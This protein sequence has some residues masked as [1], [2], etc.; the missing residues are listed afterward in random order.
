MLDASAS[1]RRRLRLMTSAMICSCLRKRL[2][3]PAIILTPGAECRL[4][5][6]RASWRSEV[7]SLNADHASNQSACEGTLPFSNAKSLEVIADTARHARGR[8]DAEVPLSIRVLEIGGGRAMPHALRCDTDLAC[9]CIASL[10]RHLDEGRT[11]KRANLEHREPTCAPEAASLAH[12]EH[13]M[14]QTPRW[15]PAVSQLPLSSIAYA[16]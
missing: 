8:D 1:A 11:R 10:A 2:R 16:S 4:S 13:P 7:H 3:L 12:M 9:C 6:I 15:V 14:P 5:K